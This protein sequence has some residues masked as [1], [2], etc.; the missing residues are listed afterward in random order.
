M[1]KEKDAKSKELPKVIQ[2]N[3]EYMKKVVENILKLLK[4]S[5]IEKNL[6]KNKINLRSLVDEVL[7]NNRV[8]MEQNKIRYESKIGKD[9][10]VHADEIL[11]KEVLYNIISNSIKYMPDGGHL[12]VS[13]EKRNGFVEVRIS[14]TGIGLSKE[15]KE[16]I[17][18]EFYKAD[19]SRHDLTSTGIGLAIC[20]RIVEAHG[21]KIWAESEGVGRGTTIAFT[22]PT[23]REKTEFIS[24]LFYLVAISPLWKQRLVIF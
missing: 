7:Y 10:F 2:R 17:F 11:L 22:I 19:E 20:K 23:Y 18:E 6:N 16:R 3:V 15:A 24:T 13:A 8:L 1:E 9:T 14:D 5:N 12:T 21:G 4:V